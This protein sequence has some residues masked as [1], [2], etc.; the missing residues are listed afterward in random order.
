[1]SESFSKCLSAAVR[2]D[3]SDEADNAQNKDD[4]KARSSVSE[5]SRT[6]EGNKCHNTCGNN[7]LLNVNNYSTD[8]QNNKVR[9]DL[10]VRSID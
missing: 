1:M 7:T 4:S 10:F 2:F 6:A 5:S 9:Y 8:E 3:E